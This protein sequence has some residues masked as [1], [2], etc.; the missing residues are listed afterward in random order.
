MSAGEKEKERRERGERA[1]VNGGYK[2]CLVSAAA[3]RDERKWMA[4][5]NEKKQKQK[6][7]KKRQKWKAKKKRK[8]C[9][10]ELV[11]CVRE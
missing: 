9:T 8:N 2:R 4:K 10:Y 7:K 11:L 1:N 5:H 3:A 6:K